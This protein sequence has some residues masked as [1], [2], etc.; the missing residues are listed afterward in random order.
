ME[1]HFKHESELLVIALQVLRAH[2]GECNMADLINGIKNRVNLSDGDM[3]FLDGAQCPRIDKIIGN[4]KTN[5]KLRRMGF[6]YDIPNGLKLTADGETVTDNE[7]AAIV[8]EYTRDGYPLVDDNG[9]YYTNK[10]SNQE[11]MVQYVQANNIVFVSSM[12]AAKEIR[13][14]FNGLGTIL[15]DESRIAA[16]GE[17][18]KTYIGDNLDNVK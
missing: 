14:G 6:V 12:T 9:R 1:H 10:L 18:V 5:E 16:I 3:V 7:L 13:K 8:A 17:L 15:T 4:I 11:A 2:G